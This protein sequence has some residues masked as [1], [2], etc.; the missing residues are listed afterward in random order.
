MPLASP[1]T[2]QARQT[3]LLKTHSSLQLRPLQL[4]AGRLHQARR[5]KGEK[6][7]S[8]HPGSG[9]RQHRS[10][11]LP[12]TDEVFGPSERDKEQREFSCREGE[13][14]KAPLRVSQ[15]PPSTGRAQSCTVCSSHS[16]LA[17]DSLCD[18]DAPASGCQNRKSL[19]L[20]C[21]EKRSLRFSSAA[22]SFFVPSRGASGCSC[23]PPESP[24]WGSTKAK[25]PCSPSW[26]LDVA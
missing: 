12:R 9:R 10:F 3:L 20:S 2:R 17:R 19:V 13:G 21:R 26:R 8:G 23:T 18:G 15:Q 11:G 6:Q 1:L 5:Q 14:K 25:A 7:Y 16:R 24:H 22:D 4:K